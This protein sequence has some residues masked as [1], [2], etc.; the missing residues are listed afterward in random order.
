MQSA[1]A[2]FET[3]ATTTRFGHLQ[4]GELPGSQS[5]APRQTTVPRKYDGTANT[6]TNH[7]S[8]M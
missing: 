4:R 1:L 2:F 3:D 7:A 8:A 6:D 5:T